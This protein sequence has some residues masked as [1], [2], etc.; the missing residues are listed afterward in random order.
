[1]GEALSTGQRGYGGSRCSTA[2]PWPLVPRLC[3]SITLS[4]PPARISN[5]PAIHI[6]GSPKHSFQHPG[7][8]DAQPRQSKAQRRRHKSEGHTANLQCGPCLVFP[9]S[10]DKD[11]NGTQ[12]PGDTVGETTVGDTVGECSF[13]S[14][15]WLL[16][17]T[18]K[19]KPRDQGQPPTLQSQ[20]KPWSLGG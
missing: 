7:G 18:D 9:Q 8:P 19:E 17:I 14:V 1:M 10:C 12:V 5:A 3:H 2:Q 6:S 15:L 13:L 20:P 4:A 11:R 16:F